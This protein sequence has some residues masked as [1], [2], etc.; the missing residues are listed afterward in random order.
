MMK[1]TAILAISGFASSRSLEIRHLSIEHASLI[2]G[3]DL[4]LSR[5]IKQD[6]ICSGRHNDPKA[7][8]NADEIPEGRR[9]N[10]I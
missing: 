3:T 9:G 1:K 7:D 4:L 5:R 2:I 10:D 8:L 6:T